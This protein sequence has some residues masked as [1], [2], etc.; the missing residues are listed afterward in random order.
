M[1]NISALLCILCCTAA[2]GQGVKPISAISWNIRY[3]NPDDG[4]NAW[5][6]RK[7]HVTGLIAYYAPDIFGIQE[8]LSDQV[9]DLKSALPRYKCIGVGRDDGDSKGEFSAVFYSNDRF[10]TVLSGTRW[11]SPTPDKPSIGWDAALPRIC[12]YAILEDVHDGRRLLVMNTHFDHQGAKARSESANLLLNTERALNPEG[13]PAILMGDFNA[14]PESEPVQRILQVFQ[15][16]RAISRQPP[17]GPE[18]T[19]NGF[20]PCNVPPWPRID[21][22]FTRGMQVLNYAT[23]THQYNGSYPSDHLPIIA[24]LQIRQ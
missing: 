24:T 22:I 7:A 17:Y 3:H 2:F 4:P 9:D 5:P 14:T 10:T 6:V 16:A 20:K 8:G 11:L 15:D 18:G 13:L 1:Q 12:T 23:L 19:F 21:Y